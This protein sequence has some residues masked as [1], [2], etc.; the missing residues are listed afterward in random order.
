M[1]MTPGV[2]RRSRETAIIPSRFLFRTAPPTD[3]EKGKLSRFDY[4]VIITTVWSERVR[5]VC[6]YLFFNSFIFNFIY[7]IFFIKSNDTHFLVLQSHDGKFVHIRCRTEYITDQLYCLSV[8]FSC[9]SV[10]LLLTPVPVQTHVCWWHDSRHVWSPARS[11]GWYT[12]AESKQ[13]WRY[14]QKS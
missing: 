7:F 9:L 3:Q 13:G 11:L 1:S 4:N 14:Q 8:I 10:S 5:L 12:S 6:F 2:W